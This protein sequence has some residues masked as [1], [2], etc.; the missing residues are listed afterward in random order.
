MQHTTL[1]KNTLY[2]LL[3]GATFWASTS[4]AQSAGPISNMIETPERV[5]YEVLETPVGTKT[6]RLW[7]DAALSS[8]SADCKE[9]KG[10]LNTCAAVCGLNGCFESCS[11]SCEFPEVIQERRADQ[12]TPYRKAEREFGAV[13]TALQ[14]RPLTRAARVLKQEFEKQTTA[15]TRVFEAALADLTLPLLAHTELLHTRSAVLPQSAVANR[16]ALLEK[17]Y[18]A[19]L[20]ERFTKRCETTPSLS[21]QKLGAPAATSELNIY[22]DRDSDALLVTAGSTTALRSAFGTAK[23]LVGKKWQPL[24]LHGTKKGIW[25]TDAH[26]LITP[27]QVRPSAIAVYVC[28]TTATPC[29]RGVW[30]TVGIPTPLITTSARA[31]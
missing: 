15:A 2:T 22:C 19:A 11:L 31:Q 5:I 12:L 28:T 1:M 8:A 20:A 26:V 14:G 7:S 9:R 10:V 4:I 13:A 27:D 6:A 21:A 18:R 25:L 23:M 29:P 16:I 17:T 3:V 30:R 24:T